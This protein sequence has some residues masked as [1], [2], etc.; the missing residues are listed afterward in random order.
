MNKGIAAAAIVLVS[1]ALTGCDR[2]DFGAD[3]NP[4]AERRAEGR[5]R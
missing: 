2:I 3:T 5:E 4:A 1:A